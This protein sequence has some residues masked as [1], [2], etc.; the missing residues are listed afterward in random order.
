MG[1][2][3]DHRKPAAKP[4]PDGIKP[5]GAM[6]RIEWATTELPL[7]K[8]KEQRNLRI[9]AD[10]VALFRRQGRGYQTGINAVLLLCRCGQAP[11]AALIAGLRAALLLR[12]SRYER[13]SSRGAQPANACASAVTRPC[14]ARST[15]A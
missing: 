7:P 12:N 10:A 14:R 9:D 2:R 5:D 11:Q 6:E 15:S 3:R 8:R 4:L 13:P 1:K